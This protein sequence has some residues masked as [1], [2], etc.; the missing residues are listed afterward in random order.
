MKTFKDL[1]SE[2]LISE[3]EELLKISPSIFKMEDYINLLDKVYSIYN[4]SKFSIFGMLL[5]E[6]GVLE[7]ASISK[8]SYVKYMKWRDNNGMGGAGV[9]TKEYEEIW[10]SHSDKEDYKWLVDT[11]SDFIAQAGKN[12]FNKKIASLITKELGN[13]KSAEY[14]LKS[15]LKFQ[16][17][18]YDRNLSGKEYY[19]NILTKVWENK[20]EV[21]DIFAR[22]SLRKNTGLLDSIKN[23]K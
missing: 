4:S 12:D 13:Q 1:I 20:S 3:F 14:I 21:Y 8:S 18:S 19:S 10:Q 2:A 15:S 17:N 9:S 5:A 16:N 11:N 22:E 6:V 7:Q 23:M